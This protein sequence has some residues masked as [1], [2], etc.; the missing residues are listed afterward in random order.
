MQLELY[1]FLNILKNENKVNIIMM[2]MVQNG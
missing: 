2:L 1:I